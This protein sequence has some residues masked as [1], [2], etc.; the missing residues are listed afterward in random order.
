MA[1]LVLIID[2]DATAVER[3]LAQELENLGVRATIQHPM[4]LTLADVEAASVLA[5]DHYLENWFER[6]EASLGLQVRDGIA[7]AAVLRSQ[8]QLALDRT[9]ATLIRTNRLDRLRG[10][11]SATASRHLVAAQHGVEWVQAKADPV[12]EAPALAALAN[13]VA[14]LPQSWVE[15]AATESDD[16]ASWLGLIDLSF[17]SAAIQQVEDAR[18]T[19][20]RV[21]QATSGMA[22]LRWFLH[23][24]LPYPTFIVGDARAALAL[25]IE[26]SALDVLIGAEAA[27]NPIATALQAAR[28]RGHLDSFLGR[29]WWRAGLQEVRWIL[30]DQGGLEPILESLGIPQL[31]SLSQSDGVIVLDEYLEPKSVPVPVAASVRI[32]VDSWPSHADDAWA[33]IDDARQSGELRAAVVA[34]DRWRLDEADAG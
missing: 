20:H 34:A 27:S 12:D 21:A 23:E 25:G 4:D 11:L 15:S 33:S 32:L 8:P 28:Y 6:D 1:P 31:R 19:S 16:I 3:G 9:S 14:S 5:V 26:A 29:R 2:D 22:F 17:R 24:A 7:L 13:A 18:P 30:E 10:D